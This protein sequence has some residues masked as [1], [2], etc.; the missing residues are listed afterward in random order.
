MSAVDEATV[1]AAA[2]EWFAAL[3][4]AVA[5]AL[6]PDAEHPGA[7][8]RGYGDVV[9]VR[10]LRAAIG[11]INPTVPA[12]A[13]DEAVRKLLHADA[14]GLVAQ[15]HRFHGFLADGVPVEYARRDGSIAGD[16]VWLADF[17]QPENNDWLVA[18]QVTVV[19]HKHERRP[20]ILVYLNGLPVGLIELKSPL[21]E[22]ATTRSRRERGCGRWSSI[23]R[24]SMLPYA[25]S[26]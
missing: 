20:D 6:V 8:R 25:Q 2:L 10:R 3:G 15:N 4:Y 24:G 9:L 13:R 26:R 22:N 18:N 1:E 11:R 19:E 14:P 16:I 5:H 21:E 7:E 23:T 17:E 12:E